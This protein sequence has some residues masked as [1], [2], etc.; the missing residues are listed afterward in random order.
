MS[1]FPVKRYSNDN[2]TVGSLRFLSDQREF[3]GLLTLLGFCAMV[4]PLY[5]LS[6]QIGSNSTT[7]NYGTP[8]AVLFGYVWLFTSGI[9]C[10]MLG[11]HALVHGLGSKAMTGFVILFIQ[12]SYIAY[13]A[14]MVAVG[15]AIHNGEPEVSIPDSYTG[16]KTSPAIITNTRFLGAMGIMGIMAYSVALLGGLTFFL[17]ALMAFQAKTPHKQNST[18]YKGHLGAFSFVL[19]FA[20]LSQFLLGCYL[21][22]RYGRL[23]G[24]AAV[25]GFYFVSRPGIAVFVGALQLMGGLAGMVH[26]YGMRSMWDDKSK[27]FLYYMGFTWLCQVVLQAWTQSAFPPLGIGA[28]FSTLVLAFS[29]PLNLMPAYLQYK[30]AKVSDDIRA[31]YYG[32][33][34]SHHGEGGTMAAGGTVMSGTHRDPE[35]T[36]PAEHDEPHIVSSGV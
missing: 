12:I 5:R 21:S 10:L 22:A 17:L 13:I 9:M 16:A 19:F 18:L 14:E 20:G 30:A 6:V 34:S 31:D 2:V 1:T 27:S 8:F 23:R 29:I 33:D 32:L 28:G 24:G 36:E 3:A 4:Q 7:T 15:K 11:Y 26:G 25:A 35:D